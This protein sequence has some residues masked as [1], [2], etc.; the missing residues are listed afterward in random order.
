VLRR[1]PDIKLHRT[2][3][4]IEQLVQLQAQLLDTVWQTLSPG[5]RMIYA[6]CSIW[7]EENQEQMAQFVQRHQEAQMDE[8]ELPGCG[9]TATGLQILPGYQSMDGFYYAAINKRV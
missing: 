1:H 6:T 2:A 5:G 3:T 9:S 4:D 7:P 8:L